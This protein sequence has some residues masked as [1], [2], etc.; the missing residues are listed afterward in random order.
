[1]V[2]N[3]SK[4]EGSQKEVKN[5]KKALPVGFHCVTSC[6]PVFEINF[7]KPNINH[8]NYSQIIILIMHFL[9]YMNILP[10]TRD[11]FDISRI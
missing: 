10:Y 3:G 4:S 8:K 7:L 5:C 6:I 1:M 9:T 11:A 2:I